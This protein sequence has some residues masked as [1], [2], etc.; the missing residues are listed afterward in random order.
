LKCNEVADST[1]ENLC[2]DC[3]T[4]GEFSAPKTGVIDLGIEV[5]MLEFFSFANIMIANWQ[6]C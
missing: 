4:E 1:A 3:F 6:Q 5:K 2:L